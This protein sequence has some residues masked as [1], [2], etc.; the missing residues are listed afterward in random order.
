MTA[1]FLFVV[2]SHFFIYFRRSVDQQTSFIDAFATLILLSYVRLLTVTSFLLLGFNYVYNS[3]GEKIG[4][5]VF[6]YDASIPYFHKE[7]LPFA[8]LAICIL[9]TFILL[10]PLLLLFYPTACFQKC[11]THYK[12]NSQALRTF[13]E[14]FNGHFKDGTNGTRDYRFFAGFYFILRIIALMISV[15]ESGFYN[16]AIS[17]IL[18][19]FMFIL[20]QPYKK[21]INNVV[22]AFIFTIM[23]TLYTL[24]LIQ[25]ISLLVADKGLS[26]TI[27]ILYSL[28]LLCLIIFIMCWVLNQKTNCI[29]KLPRYKVLS[30]I[31]QDSTEVA[32]EHFDDFAPVRLLNPTDYEEL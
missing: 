19:S 20:V 3:Q 1:R 10:P 5:P 30:C 16:L 11:L 8:L 18:Y 22:D 32:R 24:T 9:L 25:M 7:H 29:Q 17:A 6:H 31:F 23:S 13:I 14:I 15:I 4:P 28:P 27:H 21:R 26:V 12:M 2:G